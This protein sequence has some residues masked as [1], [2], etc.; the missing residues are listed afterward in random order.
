ML[1][2]K[3]KVREFYHLQIDG[4]NQVNEKQIDEKDHDLSEEEM[5]ETEKDEIVII[6]S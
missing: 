3:V 1:N 6:H 2:E 5:K 4:I